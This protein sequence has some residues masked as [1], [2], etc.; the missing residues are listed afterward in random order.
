MSDLEWEPDEDKWRDRHTGTPRYKPFL[1]DYAIT[2]SEKDGSYIVHG[3]RPRT[4]NWA[5]TL[6]K[7]MALAEDDYQRRKRLNAWH[8]YMETT[9][10]P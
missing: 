6:D 2:R 8:K 1:T 4:E 3:M 9:D 5:E 7:A 10:P